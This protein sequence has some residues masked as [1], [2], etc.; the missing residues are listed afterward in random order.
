MPV[1]DTARLAT[2]L[3]TTA[4]LA[5][6]AGVCAYL[7]LAPGGG[8]TLH[9]HFVDAGQL[10]PGNLVEV[11]GVPVGSV[12]DI[13]LTSDNQAD[14]VLHIRDDRFA[15]LHEGTTAAIRL[16][17]LSSV[18]N[19]YVAL[20]PGPLSSR[21]LPSGATLATSATGPVVDLDQVLDS[22]DPR[23]RARVQRLL[24]AG[25]QSLDGVTGA[26][27]QT[28]RYLNPALDQTAALTAELD[29]DEPALSGLVRTGSAVA[30][31][32]A[33]RTPAITHG[34][35][36][37]ATALNA[38]AAERAALAD[39]LD[40]APVVLG[41]ARGTLGRLDAALAQLRPA[42]VAARPSAGPLAALLPVVVKAGKAA[43]PVVSRL[44]RELPALSAALRG[45]PPLA[46]TGTPA[47]DN[48]ASA[49]H[50]ALPVVQGLRPYVPDLIT[51][52]FNGFGGDA[53]GYYDANGHYARVSVTGGGGSV[54][55][56][57]SLAP[58]TSG[59]GVRTGVLARC[60]GGAAEP[61]ADRSNPW[62]PDPSTCNSKDDHP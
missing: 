32:L 51:G 44:A 22:I 55:G 4:L 58:T 2:R 9:V 6:V 57:G 27:N 54:G 49:L 19:R 61:A 47:L 62:I 24:V 23:T 31:T 59:S 7:L 45:L 12:S 11:G 46:A 18:A 37:A 10:L 52:L 21:A 35:A 41:A 39:T 17:G 26:A 33:S 5:L 40:R 14:V 56:A 28:L 50:A 16:V 1:R 8:Y 25:A 60:P 20:T 34:I 43:E 13:R 36:S 30:A 3:A 42:L 53:G 48:T 29:R 38:V 15:P